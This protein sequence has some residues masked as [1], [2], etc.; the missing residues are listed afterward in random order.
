MVERERREIHKICLS[1]ISG[2]HEIPVHT[3]NAM[4]LLQHAADEKWIREAREPPGQARPGQHQ[5]SD[6]ETREIT[7]EGK[8]QVMKETHLN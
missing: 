3:P 6:R 2:A 4:K 1:N 8:K 7:R 5:E